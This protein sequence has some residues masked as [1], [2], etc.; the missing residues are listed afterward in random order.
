MNNTNLNQK[1]K[2]DFM[3]IGF[4]I[5]SMLF[6]AGNL[7]FP[8][9]LGFMTGSAW[10][11]G[12][13]GYVLADIILGVSGIMTS[14][15]HDYEKYGTVSITS[16]IDKKIGILL[17][18]TMI[19][20]IGPAVVI[21][22][23]AATTFEI[24]ILPLLPSFNPLVFSIIFFVI[25]MAFTI[26]KSKVIDVIG[27]VFTPIL[28]IALA[29]LI[30]KGIV[31]PIGEMSETAQI[32]GS[33]FGEGLS[34]GYQTMDALGAVALASLVMSSIISKGY[35]SKREKR[36]VLVKSN[37]VAA[38]FL[39]L[40]YG[41]LCYIGATASTTVDPSLGQTALL[42]TLTHLIMGNLGKVLLAIIVFFACLTT[43]VGLTSVA[44]GYYEEISGGRLNYKVLVVAICAIS[45]VISTIG[46]S[47]IIKIA[48]PLLDIIYP[49][50][51]TLIFLT[52]ISNKIKSNAVFNISAI[53]A[54]LFGVMNVLKIGFAQSLPL[55]EIGL[56][57][58]IP[59]LIVVVIT[60][61]VTNT[62]VKEN[63]IS[64]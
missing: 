13:L 64:N 22:R 42:T 3:V 28:L 20:C 41:G 48:G 46:V 57:W 8:P 44:A 1:G 63:I 36:K 35:T 33:V 49:V 6:G 10:I 47:D 53:T 54:C 31:T 55:A 17:G 58:V 9:F 7:I 25:T 11:V 56:G 45:T 30:I 34:Q 5:F 15:E 62:R 21:P 24:S 18:V 19:T 14:L 60:N 2:M 29:V 59:V 61:T 23:T 16:R 52:L 27:K 43:S 38:G 4:A 12:F 26:T 50:A 39:I 37:I 40:V 32:T 51:V